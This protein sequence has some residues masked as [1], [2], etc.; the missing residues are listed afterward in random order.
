MISVARPCTIE[1]V[2]DVSLRM[3]PW[4]LGFRRTGNLSFDFAADVGSDGVGLVVL[5]VLVALCLVGFLV[6]PLVIFLGEVSALGLSLPVVC[7]LRLC[8]VMR[9]AVVSRDAEGRVVAVEK[10]RGLARAKRRRDQLRSAPVSGRRP[11]LPPPPGLFG[12]PIRRGWLLP[13]RRA[14]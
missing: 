3:L 4:R 7:L 8:R 13:R 14:R 6:F 12:A 9:W 5:L 1:E 11:G 2:T 10:H